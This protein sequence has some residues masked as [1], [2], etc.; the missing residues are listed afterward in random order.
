MYS[1]PYE[2]ILATKKVRG[3]VGWGSTPTYWIEQKSLIMLQF[4]LIYIFLHQAEGRGKQQVSQN[5]E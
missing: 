3:A 2:S 4:K 1:L 5:E